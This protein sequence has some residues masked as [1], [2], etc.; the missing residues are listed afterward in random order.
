MDG[1]ELAR[2]QRPLLGTVAVLL[3]PSGYGQEHDRA[4]SLAGGFVHHLVKPVA[5]AEPLALI[6]REDEVGGP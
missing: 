1:E 6:A 4:R 3:A 5:P 2:R